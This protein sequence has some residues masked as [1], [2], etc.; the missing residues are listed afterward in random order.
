MN[1]TTTT[2][3]PER[4]L[5]RMTAAQLHKHIVAYHLD[6][7]PDAYVAKV[8]ARV[9]ALITGIPTRAAHDEAVVYV[10]AMQ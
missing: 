10:G 9:A 2:R 3:L 4:V 1:A 5:G 6:H 7:G 8:C